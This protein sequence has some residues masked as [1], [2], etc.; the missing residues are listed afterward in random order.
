MAPAGNG[1]TGLP[2]GNGATGLPGGN[3]ATGLPGGNGAT[4]LPGA[5]LACSPVTVQGQGACTI[6]ININIPPV[7][8]VTTPSNLLPGLHPGDLQNAYGLPVQSAGGTVAIVDAYDD[9]AAEADLAIFR[10]AYGLPPCTTDNGCFRKVN[11]QGQ[12]GSYPAA[13]VAWGEEISLDLDTV[14]AVCPNCSIVLVE[15]N[16]ALIDD[17]GAGVDSAARLGAKAISNSY[18][19]YE[20]SGETQ[21]DVHYNH[22][23]S[24]ITVS[25]GDQAAPFYPAASQY[26]TSVGGTTL[27]GSAGSW[28]ESAWTYGGQGCS[29]YV[30]RPSWQPKT[31]CKTRATVDVAAVADPQTGVSMYDSLAGGWLVAGGTSIG[32][33]LIAAAYALSGNPAGPAYS[34]AHRS[35]FHDIP[36]AGYDLPTGLG[37][38]NGTTGF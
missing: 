12:S 5:L 38:P 29:A 18:Y 15:A 23:G 22:P 27:S 8:D 36:P 13:D 7:S 11:Q 21:E 19:A 26:V 30:A 1:A 28:S 20:W 14:S 16:S 10:A 4:G 37:S 2:G 34:Y 17:L 33:P 35:A 24:A 3:G 9:P 32:A 6:A 25:A 31:A